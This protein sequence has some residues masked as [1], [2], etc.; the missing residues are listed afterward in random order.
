MTGRRSPPGGQADSPD[1]PGA[2]VTLHT[3]EEAPCLPSTGTVNFLLMKLFLEFSC[4]QKK[5]FKK[6]VIT[7]ESMS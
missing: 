4:V 5:F 3:H 7:R 1:P 2:S 6:Q